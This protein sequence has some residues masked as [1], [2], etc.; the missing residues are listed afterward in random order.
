[1]N[2]N[3]LFQDA[4]A[5]VADVVRFALLVEG[6]NSLKDSIIARVK[7][8]AEA[9][10]VKLVEVV[11]TLKATVKADLE[12]HYLAEGKSEKD[13]KASASRRAS[14]A[15]LAL[16][17]RERKRGANKDNEAEKEAQQ[18]IVD[19]LVALAVSRTGSIE[20]AVTVLRRAFAT[21]QSKK[22]SDV[23]AA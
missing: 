14:D 12:T 1:M 10:G 8:E 23:T 2:F 7:A 15:F 19:E 6:F 9:S 3:N 16:G 21:A 4:H 22:A 18:P 11:K 20:S 5:L 17:F 13:A